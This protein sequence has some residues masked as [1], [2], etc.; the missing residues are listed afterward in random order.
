[1]YWTAC[2]EAHSQALP[3][4]RGRPSCPDIS[5]PPINAELAPYPL[6]NIIS[7]SFVCYRFVNL[8]CWATLEPLFQLWTK[9]ERQSVSYFLVIVLKT[10]PLSISDLTRCSRT[11]RSKRATD[12]RF[13]NLPIQKADKAETEKRATAFSNSSIADE[14]VVS[15]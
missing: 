2:V 14:K 4:F 15:D 7:A 5:E 3:G 13:S 1:M 9:I 10:H 11:P 6:K 8:L 12:G